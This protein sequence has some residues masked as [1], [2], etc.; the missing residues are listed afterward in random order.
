MKVEVVQDKEGRLV[1][2]VC[3]EEASNFDSKALTWVPTIN[4]I[5]LI[6]KTVNAIIRVNPRRRE[7]KRGG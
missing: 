2:K 5:E 3:F 7:A 1:V 4:E 6:H